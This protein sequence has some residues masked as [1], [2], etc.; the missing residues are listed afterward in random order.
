MI[1]LD[2][3]W[4]GTD[5]V[6]QCL[7]DKKRVLAFKKSI[8]NLINKG[9][10]VVDL[11]SGSG[12]MAFLAVQFG[13]SK[14]YAVEANDCLYQ[15]LKNNVKNSA[16]SEKIEIIHGDA[17][18]VKIPEKIDMVI[19]EMI[20][21]GLFDEC[22]IP[23]MNNIQ[24]Y[25]NK[26]AKILPLKFENYIELVNANNSFYGHEIKVIQ[27]EYPW[28]SDWNPTILSS[29]ETYK[30]INF[31]IKNNGDVNTKLNIGIKKSGVV[32]AIRFTNLSTFP[33]GS[34]LGETAAYCM[35]LL[36]P[37]EEFTVKKNQTIS[38][39]LK[40]NMCK[41]LGSLDFSLINE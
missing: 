31:G 32:N 35:P 21:T 5:P 33:D 11:G 29:K 26:G 8:K 39:R 25:L 15:I 23:A 16:Y 4:G 18:N 14:V 12:I 36:Y 27:Y 19:C 24:K 30:T 7:I 17:T 1:D 3:Y 28:E 13:A 20:A 2:N 37:I 6:F 22:Q 40:Y 9:D 41:G 34:K 10:I 38:I